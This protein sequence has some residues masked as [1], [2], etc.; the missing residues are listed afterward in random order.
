MDAG[1]GEMMLADAAVGGEAAAGAG[2][3][4]ASDLVG[5]VA[6]AVADVAAPGISTGLGAIGDAS[7]TIAASGDVPMV[8]LTASQVPA[9]SSV[10]YAGSDAS[11]TAQAQQGI[12]AINP[13]T[14][15]SNQASVLNNPS[16]GGFFNSVGNFINNHPWIT[17]GGVG[18][19]GLLGSSML[20]QNQYKPP[21][22][23]NYTG[24]L[25]KY[26]FNPSSYTPYTAQNNFG[27]PTGATGGEVRGYAQGGIT[28]LGGSN[29]FPGSQQD[30]TQFNVPS[31]MPNSA[32]KADFD[33]ETNPYT[34]DIS[35]NMASGGI[36]SLGAY[37]DGGHLLKGPGDGMSDDIPA[38]IGQHQEARLADGEFVIPADVVSHLG[39]GSTDAGAQHL[40]KMM[41]KVRKA[42]TGNPKQGKRINPNKF[43]PK[44]ADGGS[45]NQY[46]SGFGGSSAPYSYA[47]LMNQLRNNPSAFQTA[48]AVNPNN[49]S[50][51]IQ[52]IA[53]NAAI[54][55]A[56][57]NAQNQIAAAQQAVPANYN[58][59]DGGP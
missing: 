44:M 51:G 41:D 45:V 54:A 3:A 6:P 22:L 18:L 43:M 39:N 56:Q 23:S 17:A 15:I 1:I 2:T 29:M 13:G 40:Y 42:R 24:P 50:L 19:A 26:S 57:Q 59:S 32:M 5:T 34:G 21:G 14:A 11:I 49:Q 16:S 35:Q 38:R 33:P 28:A 36:T 53:N 31:Q 8:D 20:S 27:I 4:V 58:G 9:A 52:S 37:S 7:G 55:Q 30:N 48:P 47:D 46:A 25:S 10:P 12:N